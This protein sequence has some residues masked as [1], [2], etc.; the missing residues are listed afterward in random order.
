VNDSGVTTAAIQIGGWGCWVGR[1]SE[2]T[3]LN[4]WNFPSNVTFSSVHSRISARI[5]S[6]NRARLSSIEIPKASNS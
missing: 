3:F 2:V 1:G 6:S 4:R 5:P